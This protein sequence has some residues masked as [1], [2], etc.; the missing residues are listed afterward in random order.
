M[1]TTRI[2]EMVDML[3]KETTECSLCF[4]RKGVFLKVFANTDFGRC[5]DSGL[6]TTC[7]KFTI[8]GTTYN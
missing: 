8:R 5:A 2:S 6:S 4:R 3:L 7:Y 1:T